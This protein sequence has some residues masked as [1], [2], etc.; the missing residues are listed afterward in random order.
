MDTLISGF[1]DDYRLRQLVNNDGNNDQLL[2]HP[3]ATATGSF[4]NKLSKF[5]LATFDDE[6]KV[7]REEKQKRQTRYCHRVYTSKLSF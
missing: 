3:L 5:T 2:D 6:G 7:K 4:T 1:A